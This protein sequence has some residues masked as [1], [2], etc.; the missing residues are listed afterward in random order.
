MAEGRAVLIVLDRERHLR[1]DIN[2]LVDL[3]AVTGL[4]L[5]Q[6]VAIHLVNLGAIRAFLWAGL[7]AEDPKLTLA[8]AGALL[9]GVVARGGNLA[10]VTTKMREALQEAGFAAP[11]GAPASEGGEAAGPFAASAPGS[12]PSSPAPSATSA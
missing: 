7:K 8:E 11:D 6:R 4:N 2:A 3:E 9:Q 10:E 5:A 12:A 1:Y